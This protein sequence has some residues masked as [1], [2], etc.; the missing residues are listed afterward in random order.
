MT[1]PNDRFR[2]GRAFILDAP[3]A[4]PALWGIGR[5]VLWAAGEP[6]LVCGPQG[7]GKSTVIQQLAFARIGVLAPELIGYPVAPAQKRVL[8]LA[9]DRPRQIA[10]SM[11]RMITNDHADLLAARLVVWEGPLPFDLAKH[12]EL[13]AEWVAERDVDDVYIDSLKDV[14][15]PLTNDEVGATYNRAVAGVIA[16][17]VEVVVNHH[18]RKAT[19]ENKKPSSLA[20]VYGSVWITSGAGS[21]ICLWGQAGDPLVELTHLK[22]PAEEVGPLDLEHDH[23]HG[24]TTRRERPDAWALLQAATVTGLTAKDAA[25]TLYAN[26]SK[27]DVEKVRRRLARFVTDGH[28]IAIPATKI[29]EPTTYWPTSPNGRVSTREHE[30]EQLT[31]RSRTLTAKHE[32]PANTGRERSRKPSRTLTHDDTLTS[33]LKEWGEREHDGDAPDRTD[34]QLDA[35][36]DRHQEATG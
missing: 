31:P 5:E 35:L 29:T 16:T 11:R 4:V 18:Q 17:G 14:A 34:E 28:A 7:V 10:R 25:A 30:R 27:A 3:T 23:E 20:D 36:I 19:S 13:L 15:W 26:P 6:L 22:Q 32:N 8:Y 1:E 2:D 33:P 24:R 12:P 21:V 9:A